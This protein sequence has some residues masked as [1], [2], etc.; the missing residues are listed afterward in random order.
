VT[1]LLIIAADLSITSAGIA[2][3][4]FAETGT[5]GRSRCPHDTRP[6]LLRC[7]ARSTPGVA[8]PGW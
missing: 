3:A 5:T 6:S 8:W 2:A 7:T 4:V 1:D